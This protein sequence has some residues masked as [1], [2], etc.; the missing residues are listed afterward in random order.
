MSKKA[1]SCHVFYKIHIS[2]AVGGEEPNKANST[3]KS[4]EQMWCGWD[5]E[6][7]S[8]GQICLMALYEITHTSTGGD[9]DSHCVSSTVL[10]FWVS[11][12]GHT[13]YST[14]N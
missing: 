14:L 4:W 8:G 7:G 6:T 2:E 12:H 10:L 9:L 5:E 13:A 1:K 11:N 3:G